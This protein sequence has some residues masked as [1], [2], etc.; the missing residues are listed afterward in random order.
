MNAGLDLAH[1]EIYR[2][3]MK[4]NDLAAL[5]VDGK[6]K[7]KRQSPYQ[8]KSTSMPSTQKPSTLRKNPFFHIE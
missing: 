6:V 7:E 3:I 4:G 5:L 2:D 8:C 1:R